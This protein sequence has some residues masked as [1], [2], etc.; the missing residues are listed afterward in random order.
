M[1]NKEVVEI[2]IKIGRSPELTTKTRKLLK[3]IKPHDAIDRLGWDEW[4]DVTQ[5]MTTD[6]LVALI[7]GLTVAE[8]YHKWSGGS[9]SAVIWTFRELERRDH[10]LSEQLAD[11]ILPRTDNPY[12]PFG[13]QNHG[14]T[15]YREFTEIECLQ[16][17]MRAA[18]EKERILAEKEAREQRA[19]RK[20]QRHR[21]TQHRNSGIREKMIQDL[22]ELPV[23][24]QLEQIAADTRYSVTFYPTLCAGQARQEILESLDGEIRLK[25]LEKMKGKHRG[26]WGKF[27][28]RL[29]ATFPD[30]ESSCRKCRV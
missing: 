26:S 23:E 30:R 17:M 22:R 14:A 1:I 2:L 20:K 3:A 19:V 24:E 25:L 29:L 18:G 16:G 11:W 13:S 27:K 12:A 28:K 9:V 6:D 7:K 21:S 10:D 5:P 15:S 4:D 8:K